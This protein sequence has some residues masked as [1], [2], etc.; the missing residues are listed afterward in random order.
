[1]SASHFRLP[2]LLLLP[3]LLALP[4]CRSAPGGYARI[5]PQALARAEAEAET[6]PDDRATYLALIAR[7]EE[8][9]SWFAALAHIEAFRQKFGNPPELRLLQARAL[10]ETRQA[11][12]AETIY[13]DLLDGPQAAAAWHG[14]GLIA[15]ARQQGDDAIHQLAKA[16]QLDPLNADYQGDLGYAYLRIGDLDAARAPLAKA[17]ELAP[18]N[19]HALVNLALWAMLNGETGKAEAILRQAGLPQASR[20]AVYRSAS[21]LRSAWPSRHDAHTTSSTAAAV[22]LSPAAAPAVTTLASP[23]DRPPSRM[24][25]RFSESQDSSLSKAAQ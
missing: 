14:L 21:D 3:A 8:Q 16:A 10:H 17:A 5:D 9:G 22:K 18:G 19:A 6:R 11:D 20:D 15:A 23:R 12:A 13:R 2:V 4:A 1:M 7:M 24:L 25:Q